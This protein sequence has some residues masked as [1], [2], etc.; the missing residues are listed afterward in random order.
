MSRADQITAEADA[1]VKSWPKV[2]RV[3]GD[4]MKCQTAGF[5]VEVGEDYP[6]WAADMGAVR[7][8]LVERDLLEAMRETGA[9]ASTS[10]P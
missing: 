7:R 10:S 5:I 1:T 3:P 9:P 2:P 8:L 6:V 4:Y